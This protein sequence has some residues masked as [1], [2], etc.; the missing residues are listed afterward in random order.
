MWP[1]RPAHS[2][3]NQCFSASRSNSARFSFVNRGPRGCRFSGMGSVTTAFACWPSS[4]SRNPYGTACSSAADIPVCGGSSSRP[5]EATVNTRVSN[6]C[7]VETCTESPVVS[8]FSW[9]RLQPEQTKQNPRRAVT[10]KS[11]HAP[12]Q[13]PVSAMQRRPHIDDRKS[14][15]ACG[16][17]H[18]IRDLKA[19]HRSGLL[20]PIGSFV[21]A[22]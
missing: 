18:E 10:D 7:G 21:T 15:D 8:L 5:D 14:Q 1:S 13:T 4:P 19:D 2:P 22:L 6:P 9:A 17:H 12:G 11:L 16:C 20:H 3:G